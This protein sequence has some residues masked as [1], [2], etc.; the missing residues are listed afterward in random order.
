MARAYIVLT[1]NDIEDSLLQDLDLWPPVLDTQT[2]GLPKVNGTG[3][4]GYLT[5]YLIDGVNLAVTLDNPGAGG[6]NSRDFAAAVPFHYGLSTYLADNIERTGAANLALTAAQA[7]A[8]SVLIEA[9]ANAGTTL[10]LAAINADI[11]TATEAGNDL[12]GVLGNSTGTVEEVLRILA[13]ER[14][15]VQ[16]GAVLQLQATNQ[17]VAVRRGAFVTAP[18]VT[19]IL[20]NPGG[21]K[22]GSQWANLTDTTPVWPQN[23]EFQRVRPIQDT[24]DLHLSALSGALS[25]LKAATFTWLNPAFTYAGGATPA[26]DLSQTN[27]PVTGVFRAVTIYDVLGNVI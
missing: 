24:G 16:G 5:F 6:V 18:P 25:K 2:E 26:Q 12:N 19:K 20:T 11:V 1:R 21:R 4:G 8:I 3:Q 17:F 15:A 27:I 22:S 13:G 14:Y 7:V 9:R 10:N 23:V